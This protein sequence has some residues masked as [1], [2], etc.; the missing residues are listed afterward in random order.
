MH[1]RRQ[2]LVAC[3]LLAFCLPG[4]ADVRLPAIIGEHMVLQAGTNT[5][6][7]GR[8]DPGEKVTVSSAGELE[9]SHAGGD[10]LLESCERIWVR[11]CQTPL[12]LLLQPAGCSWLLHG[13]IDNGS[14]EA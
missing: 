13:F 6:I 10:A 7:W 8:A 11:S 12:S 14:A 9:H 5:P 1:G 2:F 4:F 3:F